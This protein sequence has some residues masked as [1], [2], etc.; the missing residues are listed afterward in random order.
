M[1]NFFSN[2]FSKKSSSVLGVDVGS[3]SIK[4]VQLARK[5]GHAVLETYGEL[6]LGPYA[7][8]EVGRSTNLSPE[9]I[10]EAL[11]D[12]IRESKATASSIGVSIPFGSSLITAV[13]MPAIAQKN[14]DQIVPIEAR[15]YIPVPIS[16]VALD[17]WVIPKSMKSPEFADKPK[18]PALQ[19]KID[20]LLVAIHNDILKK[21]QTIVDAAKLSASFFEIEIFS[22]IR[23]ALDQD[24]SSQMIIDLGAA[25]SKIYIVEQGVVRA[26][27]IVNRGAQDVTLGI[28]RALGVSVQNA[29]VM[30][31]DM[32]RIPPDK[33]NDVASVIAVPLDYIFAEAHQVM[34]SY[35]RKYSKDV[36]KA[37]M[38]GG[39]AMLKGVLTYAEA[40]LQTQVL[41]GDPFGKTESPAFLAEVLKHTGPEFAVAVGVA[42]RKLTEL[43]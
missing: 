11:V 12:V 29:E 26:S 14:F 17:W 22:S 13:E 19:E 16:E 5:G 32:T 9:K 1:A 27:H 7:G 4:I 35:Q 6:S 15:K 2:L 34:L 25:S 8:V 3:S 21:Y 10:A 20:V 41:L 24:P 31:R 39:G 23:S 40:R 42:L 18:D 28:S 37:F 30:K 43:Q 33:K 38:V 36:P